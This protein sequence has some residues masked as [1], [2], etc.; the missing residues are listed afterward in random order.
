MWI[1]I[2]AFVDLHST[3]FVDIHNRIVDI[4]NSIVGIH[5]YVRYT[6][7][8]MEI[9]LALNITFHVKHPLMITENSSACNM[10]FYTER[11]NFCGQSWTIHTVKCPFILEL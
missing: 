7:S 1:S 6:H 9:T 4:L 3:Q 2:N 11:H 10:L 8:I 5:K